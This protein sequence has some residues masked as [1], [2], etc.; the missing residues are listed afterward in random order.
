MAIDSDFL[1]SIYEVPEADTDRRLRKTANVGHKK[2]RALR[3]AQCYINIIPGNAS[4][5]D[6]RHHHFLF[7]DW[8]TNGMPDDVLQETGLV[9]N[10]SP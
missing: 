1:P 9:R 10:T 5:T 7:K 4:L 8:R 3:S 2:E 6:E